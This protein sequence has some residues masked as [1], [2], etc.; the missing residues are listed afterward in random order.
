MGIFFAVLAGLCWGIGEVCARAVLHTGKI[1]PFLAVAIRSSVALP[2]IWGAYMV[3]SRVAP[4]TSGKGLNGL[5]AKEWALLLGGSGLV[6][7][8]AAMVC[9]YIA[10]SLGE[11]SRM[12]PI[13]FT[14]APACAVVLGG[15]F[16]HETITLR[17]VVALVLVVSGVLLL[18]AP[19]NAQHA[20]DPA[21]EGG[22][23]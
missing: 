13:A 18:A 15:L 5:N 20:P 12:K 6:A 1:G 3:A 4:T 17:K 23:R 16:L 14:L 8:A 2:V 9:F 11:V 10:I 19:T 22:A 7:G 21:A